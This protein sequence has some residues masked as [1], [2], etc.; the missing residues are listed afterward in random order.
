M[1]PTSTPQRDAQT[2]RGVAARGRR[3]RRVVLLLV[4]M[5]ALAILLAGVAA[6][7]IRFN[8]LSVGV[9]FE[10]T[11]IHAAF[12]QVAVLMVPIWTIFM[13][14]AGLYDIDV[15]TWGLSPAGKV[16]RSLS[17]GVVAMILA[18]YLLK[19]PGLS[20]AWTLLV[21]VLAIVFV[22]LGRA[23]IGIGATIARS[24]GR[25]RQPTIVV[26]ANAEAADIIRVLLADTSAGLTPIGCV[27]SS[28]AERLEL[29]FCSEDLPLLGAARDIVPIVQES[30]AETVVIAS[31]AFDHDILARM[32]AE[33]RAI[34]VDVHISSGLFEVLTS[35]VLVTEV[36]G[37]PLITIRGISLSRASLIT[38]RLFDISVATAVCVVGLPLW[39]VLAL[40]VRLSSRGPILYS[41]ERVGRDGVRF[42]MYKFRSMY[43]DADDRLKELRHAN[44]ASGLMFKMK[45]D[46]RVT[47]VGKW[48]RRYWL[49]EIPQLLNVLRGTMSLV[50]PRPPLPAEVDAYS[51][52][53]WR[54]LEVVPGMT[55]LWQVSGRS[56]LTFDEM[57]RLDIF[58]IENWSVALDVSLMFRTIPAVLLA[59]GAY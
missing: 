11:S 3:R 30:G 51:E 58:Y 12:W 25:L 10:N 9:G 29:D 41:Q 14:F 15:L 21:W 17:L 45:E 57:V 13:A 39:L 32:I 37:V 38:K 7:V 20:R 2:P 44:E 59:R 23:L 33:L 36:A 19:T 54:R 22:L 42:P 5:D 34:D 47:P 49:D 1:T 46:P 43:I 8:S 40:A 35:R 26:G 55:G 50:G 6:T 4:V 48:L 18:T 52:Q 16:I 56:A 28:R 31:S 53:H 27:A 24:R